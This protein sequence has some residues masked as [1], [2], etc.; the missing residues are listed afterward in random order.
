MHIFRGYTRKFLT[1]TFSESR[2]RTP[3]I[4][5]E[6]QLSI[7]GVAE[8]TFSR[9]LQTYIYIYIFF[10]PAKTSMKNP[11]KATILNTRN[12]RI[13]LLSA[14]SLDYM[15]L[16]A[17]NNIRQ[18]PLQKAFA[19][20]ICETRIYVALSRMPAHREV[21]HPVQGKGLWHLKCFLPESK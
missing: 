6:F 14:E 21:N 17:H 10:V 11:Y 7:S 1:T 20:S 15:F 18:E 9:I 3:C 4:P 13:Y 2:V 19:V 16:C 8:G 12:T 5:V